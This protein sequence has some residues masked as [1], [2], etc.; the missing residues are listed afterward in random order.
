M[1]KFVVGLVAIVATTMAVNAAPMP[2]IDFTTAGFGFTNGQWSLGFQFA[3]GAQGGRVSQ[4]G[5]WDDGANGLT[6][7]HNVGIYNMSGTLLASTTITNAN[8]LGADGFRYGNIADLILA[9]NTSYVIAATT[10]NEN[11]MWDPVGFTTSPLITFQ[12]DRYTPSTTLAFPT[13]GPSGVNGW[14]GPNFIVSEVPEPMS[15]ALFG[16][17]VAVGGVVARRRMK[18]TA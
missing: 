18:V 12:G 17:L 13:L 14:F 10:G 15:L 16:G 7:S 11:Y 8:A 9:A 4:L 6:Q 1:R 3:T 2:A 5:F